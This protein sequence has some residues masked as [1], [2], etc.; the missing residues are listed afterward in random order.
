MLNE[1]TDEELESL[2]CPTY[3]KQ[4]LEW[5]KI[6]SKITFDNVKELLKPLNYEL[7]KLDHLADTQGVINRIYIL[8]VKN[9]INNLNQELILR[10]SNP[11]AFWIHRRT[12]SEVSV[13]KYLKENTNI[14]VP[15]IYG[16]SI[17]AINILECEYILMEKLNGKT[18]REVLIEKQ[19]KAQDIPETLIDEMIDVVKCLHSVKLNANN[20]IGCFDEKMNLADFL[21]DGATLGVFD[22]FLSFVT[23]YL[24]HTVGGNEKIKKISRIS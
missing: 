17:D 9:S 18:L 24:N 3:Q 11:H 5:Q 22:N 10:I 20:K 21:M 12:K 2:N 16:Y 13:I 6:I 14:P 15:F 7:L 8:L 23:T 19:L 1:I 4:D